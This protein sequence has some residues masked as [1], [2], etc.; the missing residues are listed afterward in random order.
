MSTPGALEFE[1]PV[2]EL[3]A[4]ITE[5]SRLVGG[6]GGTG[7]ESELEKLR[8]QAHKRLTQ[9]YNNLDPWQ[10]CQVARH[11]DRPQFKALAEQLLTDYQPLSGD[12]NFG[13]DKAILGGLA[14]FRERPVVVMGHEKGHDMASR[15]THN[16]GMGRPE[17]Y[18]KAIRLMELADQFGLP[19]LSFVD[20][21][22]AYPGK[23]AEERGQAEAIARSIQAGLRLQVPSIAVITGEGGSGGAVALAASNRV[24]MYEHAVYSVISPEGCASILWRDGKFAKDAAGALNLTA[25]D[26]LRL[27]VIDDIVEEPVGGAHRHPDQAAQ[28]LGDAIEQHL[29][30]LSG[31]A[32]GALKQAREQRFLAIGREG[33]V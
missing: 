27:G 33:L 20:T 21:P 18:R 17:G 8:D 32:G 23:G 29:Q 4:K 15:V 9:V 26:L 5:L 10:K 31:M 25:Q 16:F 30:A 2:K 11:P 1:K 19:V 13:D 28:A 12:R 22:G 24:L 7:M 6:D 14:R 3:E